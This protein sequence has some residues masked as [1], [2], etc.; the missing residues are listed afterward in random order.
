MSS[1]SCWPPPC[2]HVAD[3]PRPLPPRW[4]DLS[5]SERDDDD[6]ARGSSAAWPPS[7]GPSRQDDAFPLPMPPRRCGAVVNHGAAGDRG[8]PV[9]PDPKR[10]EGF[11]GCGGVDRGV[12]LDGDGAESDVSASADNARQ[13]RSEGALVAEDDVGRRCGGAAGMRGCNGSCGA[14]P[15]STVEEDAGELCGM[16][17]GGRRGASGLEDDVSGLAG[18]MMCED[19]GVADSPGF[20]AGRPVPG[21]DD[22]AGVDDDGRQFRPGCFD[23]NVLRRGK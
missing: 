13:L 23:M 9:S 2:A 22:D 20:G 3:V 1:L 6:A 15:R 12:K 10:D 7:S 19:A 21:A 5:R 18:R 17:G 8:R 14:N 11:A 16:D 4:L